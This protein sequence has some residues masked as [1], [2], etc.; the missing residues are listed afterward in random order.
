MPAS[1]HILLLW[2]C[3][4]LWNTCMSFTLLWF[5]CTPHTHTHTHTHTHSLSHTHTQIHTRHCD[6]VDIDCPN[7][8]GHSCQ[9]RY[10]SPH[11]LGCPNKPCQCPTCS[12]HFQ[13]NRMEEHA[14]HCSRII[15]PDCV[16]N[17]LF[18]VSRVVEIGREPCG[19]DRP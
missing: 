15:L 11:L 4:S 2:G 6:L 19:Q 13:R 18:K 3:R 9:R 1:Y 17:G 14:G 5:Q 10:L 16:I 12:I 8:C 7:T